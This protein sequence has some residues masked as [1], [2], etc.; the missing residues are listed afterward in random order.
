MPILNVRAEIEN[1]PGEVLPAPELLADGGPV[2]P[3]TI[4]L[5]DESQRAYNERGRQLPQAVTGFAL[6]DTGASRTCFDKDSAIEAGLPVVDTATMSSA[7]HAN[8][9]VPVFMGKIILL[10][11]NIVISV[12]KGLG[13]NLSAFNGLVAL[14]GRDLLK[15]TIF[16]YNGPE[17]LISVSI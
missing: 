3:V 8:H 17:G 5:S 11:T 1:K 6:I 2:I 12:E 13:A 16:T 9:Q 7:T 15:N 14:I 10:Q 4:T